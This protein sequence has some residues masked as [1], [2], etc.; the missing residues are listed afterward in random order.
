[1][2]RFLGPRL[3]S[4]LAFC[5]LLALALVGVSWAR[6]TVASAT[7]A[8]APAARTKAADTAAEARARTAYGQLPLSFEA[9]RGQTDPQVN[10]IARGPGYNVFLTPGEAVLVLAPGDGADAGGDGREPD[11]SAAPLSNL[12]RHRAARERAAAASARPATVLRMQLLGTTARPAAVRGDAELPGKVNYL[13]GGDPNNW[14]TGIPTYGQVRYE[15]VYPGVDLVYYGNQQQ[16]E[17][18]FVVAPG[19]DPNVIGLNYDG[20]QA[21]KLAGDG[22]LVL[23]TAGGDLRQLKPFVYQ[24]REDG[25]RK[26]INGRYVLKGDGRV[27]FQL[28]KYDRS[29]PLVIDPVL[30][31]LSFVNANGRGFAIAV[32]PSGFAYVAGALD[33]GSALPASSGAFQI[34]GAGG[35]D[36]FVTKLNQA[37]NNVLYATFLGGPGD[38]DA[39]GLALDA[40]GSAYVTGYAR[41]GFPTT[42]GAFKT[43][44]PIGYDAFVTKLNPAG[45]GLVY[46]TFFGGL[47]YEE[48][49]GITVDAAGNAYVA[50]ITESTD[51]PTTPGAVL[52]TNRGGAD[53]F[54][55]EFNPTG[56]ALLYATYIAGGGQDYGL[57]VAVDSAGNIYMVGQTSSLDAPSSLQPPSGTDRGLFKTTNGGTAWTLRRN[58]LTTGFVNAVAVAPN[59]P[60]VVYAGTFGGVSKSTDAGANWTPTGQLSGGNVAA[61]AV[62]PTNVNVVYAGSPYGVFKTTNGGTNWTPVNTGLTDVSGIPF[63]VR[64]LA[65]DRNATA[66]VYAATAAGMY[67]STNGGGSWAAINTGITTFSMRA[68]VIDPTN[69]ATLYCLSSS[70]VFKSTNSGANWAQV[71]TGLP[72]VSTYVSLAIDPLSPA[73]LYVGGGAGVYKTT[74]GGTSWAAAT[75]NLLLP[76]T[77]NVGRLANVV[78]LAVDPVTPGVVYAG[79]NNPSLATGVFPVTATLKSTDGGAN[80]AAQTTGFNTSNSSVTALAIDPT[81]PA[82]VY[83]GTN[84]DTEAFMVKI[85]PGNPTLLFSSYIGGART[86]TALGVTV[87][88]FGNAYITGRTASANFPV[89]AGA[90]QSALGG[91]AD[92]FLVKLNAP[93]YTPAFATYF[94][95]GR[96]EEGQG[97]ALDPAGNIYVAGRTGSLNLPVTAGS[98]QTKIGNPGTVG[99]SDMFVTKFNPSGASLSYS[100]YLGGAGSEALSPFGLQLLNAVAVDAFGNAYVVGITSD[101]TTFPAFDFINGSAPSAGT[102]GTFVAKVST[103]SP[104]YS[105]TGHLLTNT[106]APIVGAEVEVYDANGR[107]LNESITDS[108]GYYELISLPPGD[109]TVQPCGC[110]AGNFS[111]SPPLRNFTGL[112]ADQTADFTGTPLYQ[113]QGSITSVGNNFG[114]GGVTVT[115]SGAA[116]A[117]AITNVDGSYFFPN[118]LPNGNYTVTPSRPG[119]TF[120]PVNRTLTNLSADQFSVNFTT[121]SAQFFNVTGRVADTNNVGVSGVGIFPKPS[122]FRL[123]GINGIFTDASG[124]YTITNVQAD[125]PTTIIPVKQALTFSPYNPTLSNLVGPTT[126]NFTA[127]AAAGLTGQIAY[128]AFDQ[129]TNIGGIFIANANGTGAVNVTNDGAEVGWSPDGTKLVFVSDRDSLP[130]PSGFVKDDIYTINADGTGLVRLTNNSTNPNRFVEDGDPAWSPDGGRIA[131]ENGNLECSGADE[132]VL[133]Q[134]YAINADGTN[135]TQLTGGAFPAAFPSW[136]PDG[137]RLTFARGTVAGDCSDS[138][139]DIW[140]MNA[141]G[142]AQTPLTNNPDDESEPAWSPDGTKIAFVKEI[143]GTF[144]RNLYVMNADG[145]GVT[146]LTPFLADADSPTW[147]PNGSRIAFN[148]VLDF[149]PAG[150]GN[151][152]YAINADGTGL[153]LITTGAGGA[154]WRPDLSLQPANISG[155]ISDTNGVGVSGATVTLAGTQG[156]T[157]I[158]DANGFYA[159][160]G[161]QRNGNYTVTPTLAGR[162]FSPAQQTANNLLGTRTANFSSAALTVSVSGRVVTD[163]IPAAGL[164]GVTVTLSGSAGGTTTTDA[165]G[166]YT[167]AGLAPGGNYTV[168]PART[169]YQFDL[170]A[171]TF[172]NALVNQRADF[173]ATLV[174]VISGR[175]TDTATGAGL[176]GVTITVSG[177]RTVVTT[178]DAGGNYAVTVAAGG[179]YS[180]TATSPYY[181]F[182]PPRADFPN[183]G[184]PQTANFATVPA[185]VPTPTPPLSDNF[186]TPARDP[187]KWNLGTLSQDPDAVDPLV[188]VVQRAG[189]LEITPLP[190]ATGEHFN[191]Y[192]SVRPFDFTSGTAVVE[193]VQTTTSTG[194]TIFGLGSDSQNNYRFVVTTLGAAPPEVRAALSAGGWGPLDISTLVLVFQVRIGGVVTQA[195]I[196]YDPVAHRFWR[197]RHDAPVNA[198][199]FETSPDNS[200]FTERFRKSL[201]KNVSALAVELTAGTAEPT[202]GGGTA[203]FDNLN[204]MTSTVA[205]ASAAF[206]VMENAS[207]ATLT[208]TRSGGVNGPATVTYTTVDDPAEVGCFDQVNNHGASYARCDYATSV[209]TLSF[210]PGETQ[211]TLVIPVIDDSFVEGDETVRVIL[212]N[213][214]GCGLSSAVGAATLT[215]KDNDQ[216]GQPNP[217]FEP[218]PANTART[219]PFFVR[220]HYLD[221]LAR[222]PEQ[223][224]PWTGVLTRC[225][226]LAGGSPDNINN[227]DPNSP[228]AGCDRLIVSGSFFGSPEFKDKGVYLIVFYRAAFNR[229]PTYAEFAQDLR[230]LTGAT[231]A[232]TFAKR[233]SFATAFTQRQEFAG[234]YGALANAA[235]VAALLGRYQLTQI[236]CPD[237]AQPDGTAKVTL[238]STELTSR[239]A[240]GTLTRAQVLR[241]VVQSDE[242]SQQREAVNAFVAAQYYGFLRRAPDT[243]GFNNWVNYLTSH[244]GDFRTMV[245]GFMNSTEYRLRFG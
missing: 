98:F 107:F 170:P 73:T 183:L 79:A 178:T 9:N 222:E 19:A 243:G 190:N 205:F 159:F 209:D 114:V 52:A 155:R 127:T 8:K 233:A 145:T 132:L 130:D 225:L 116:S 176:A 157:T 154:A 11:A 78:A 177:T 118:G 122:S 232:E 208:V 82:I 84:G 191:G 6:R 196:P 110:G 5:L 43:T 164:G 35:Q 68:V 60:T 134:I 95:G 161:I 213:P 227:T 187:E 175:V 96:T 200:A 63:S 17:Y 13:F 14:R 192:V 173:V 117:T 86:D 207:A 135:R 59:S 235:Y 7:A 24:P 77:D 62:D 142:S 48:G 51:L 218:N 50:G 158:T 30:S 171:R 238:T 18:D 61:L 36:V 193:T 26:Q 101:R 99:A 194:Q 230:S 120:T 237:P 166:N 206:T 29:K 125:L 128:D 108:T 89:T 113:I 72:N 133:S 111:F 236:T 186:N 87:D 27:G 54:V 119:Y 137:T 75:N 226:T 44:L 67:K 42:A 197:F 241:A 181:L 138:D 40:A 239:L 195:V 220:Q 100:S 55:A 179:T 140:V 199:L 2:P 180:V 202:T 153:T 31:Y 152:I 168:T 156:G 141:D 90:F 224:E 228:S 143:P 105:I 16:L 217:V 244:P 126:L 231:P 74:N 20:A 33:A 49:D 123:T 12:E 34:A 39:Y 45:S 245:N 4:V 106:A 189:H 201:E 174:Y 216:A 211:K 28:G 15:Q 198:I 103:S 93:N 163:D 188:P 203:I 88:N 83:A 97:I 146:N 167:F 91:S 221:F 25:S 131:F 242:V 185:A 71:V 169:N 47:N 69:S 53:A 214:S 219:I 58:G 37:G 165:N 172:N 76:H 1:M 144:T 139:G 136:A 66:T 234:Q 21:V 115:L 109:Y 124:N 112:N 182:T 162:T 3:R 150:G 229:L 38:D 148:G 10:F 121:S 94:G 149:G 160:R 41:P 102:T 147:S 240:G 92:A 210:A 23:K 151:P 32:D 212:L 64:G 57:N 223:G 204:I 215:I 85:A 129:A 81:N 184:G 56:S 46:S 22:G 65:V 80:W 104:S 70:R